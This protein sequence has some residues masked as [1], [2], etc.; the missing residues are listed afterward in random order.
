MNG[1]AAIHRETA[2][3][4]LEDAKM[5]PELESGSE[6][7]EEDDDDDDDSD[8]SV[9]E[10]DDDEEED[11]E[12]EEEEDS[13]NKEDE[14]SSTDAKKK[15]TKTKKTK[16][17]DAEAKKTKAKGKEPKKK[18]KKSKDRQHKEAKT[19]TKKSDEAKKA[20]GS[21]PSGTTGHRAAR[22][23]KPGVTAARLARRLYT[24]QA[25]HPDRAEFLGQS[26][27]FVRLVER[28]MGRTDTEKKT[29]RMTRS[30]VQSLRSIYENDIE[31]LVAAAGDICRML[32]QTTLSVHHINAAITLF[33]RHR[34][35]TSLASFVTL[36]E[37]RT[38]D[39]L[40]VVLQNLGGSLS[41]V[42]RKTSRAMDT[43][44]RIIARIR[45]ALL[46]KTTEEL[47]IMAGCLNPNDTRSRRT[48]LEEAFARLVYV[49]N[50]SQSSAIDIEAAKAQL[51]EA[52]TATHRPPVAAT[53]DPSPN[54]NPNLNAQIQVQA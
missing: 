27:P 46:L 19:T 24:D 35:M 49:G 2:E 32:G 47:R 39:E 25:K 16:A 51:Q 11:E 26:E 28:V 31:I 22:R 37:L 52:K 41:D 1:D 8:A 53:P 18:K 42:Q 38:A 14:S 13:S 5:H 34:H 9:Y 10:D 17:K 40:L 44:S 45:R 50:T 12:D 48:W 33:Q 4:K 36:P 30:S 54:P 15:K 23:F 43:R 3:Q 7:G 6:E 20:K 29:V 21:A